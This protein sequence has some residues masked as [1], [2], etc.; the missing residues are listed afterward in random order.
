MTHSQLKILL[1][2]QIKF[3]DPTPLTTLPIPSL[4]PHTIRELLGLP[5]H[6]IFQTSSDS[7]WAPAQRE[8]ERNKDFLSEQTLEA[9]DWEIK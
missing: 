5:E 1:S 3:N 4:N 8:M 2:P 6:P 7:R 9:L